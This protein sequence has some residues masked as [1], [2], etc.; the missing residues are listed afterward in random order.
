MQLLQVALRPTEFHCLSLKDAQ[1][2][3]QCLGRTNTGAIVGENLLQAREVYIVIATKG[4]GF[5][6]TKSN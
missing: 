6:L 1:R 4:V 5:V 3:T 2:A